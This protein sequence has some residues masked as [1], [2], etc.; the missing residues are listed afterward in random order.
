MLDLYDYPYQVFP[1]PGYVQMQFKR[2]EKCTK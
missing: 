1:V 2:L